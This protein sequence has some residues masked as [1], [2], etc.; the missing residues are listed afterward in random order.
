MDRTPNNNQPQANRGLS[1]F[2][3]KMLERRRQTPQ[4]ERTDSF[5]PNTPVNT[6]TSHVNTDPLSATASIS[7]STVQEQASLQ[8]VSSSSGALPPSSNTA[9]INA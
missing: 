1:N 2:Q 8:A 6:D 5:P 9:S 7:V 3:L 4:T